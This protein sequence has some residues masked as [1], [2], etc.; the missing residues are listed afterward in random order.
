MNEKLSNVDIEAK[1]ELDNDGSYLHLIKKYRDDGRSNVPATYVV[2]KRT[3]VRS[4]GEQALVIASIAREIEDTPE[5]VDG[6]YQIE[7]YKDR[8]QRGFYYVVKSLK[9]NKIVTI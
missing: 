5:I 9:F 2:H 7:G 1:L 4:E 3:K 8:A 6:G